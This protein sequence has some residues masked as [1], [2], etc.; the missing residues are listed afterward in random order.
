MGFGDRA[1]GRGVR[2]SRPEPRESGGWLWRGERQI[3]ASYT[4]TSFL[5]LRSHG[6]RGKQGRGVKCTAYAAYFMGVCPKPEAASLS[7]GVGGCSPTT[8]EEEMGL[9]WFGG[10]QALPGKQ[11]H[12]ESKTRLSLPIFSA[13]TLS[14]HTLTGTAYTLGHTILKLRPFR[15]SPRFGQRP[16]CTYAAARCLPPPRILTEAYTY[17]RCDT[18][19]NTRQSGRRTCIHLSRSCTRVLLACLESVLLLPGLPALPRTQVTCA[20]PPHRGFSYRSTRTHP[21]THIHK[22][23]GSR[24]GQEAW[25]PS[26]SWKGTC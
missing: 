2:P 22:T 7:C 6:F 10:K 1:C 15:S 12:K 18:S 17:S 14:K 24:A 26:L 23:Q 8:L 21:H 13:H 19:I 16:Q 11:R 3:P 4:T 20:R 9:P 5:C 25:R